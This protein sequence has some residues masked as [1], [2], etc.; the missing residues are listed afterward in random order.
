MKPVW[1]EHMVETLL[2]RGKEIL[3]GNLKKPAEI[4]YGR[5]TNILSAATVIM[6][7]IAASRLLGLA[8][9][10]VFVHYFPPAQLD[11]YLA[12]FQLPDLIFEVFIL[13]AMS[14]AFIPIFAKSLSEGKEKEAW[15]VAG[16]ILNVM[17]GLF[18]I[19]S[20]L[21]FVF[22]HPMYSLVAKGFTPDQISQTVLF[23][24]TL[25][26]AQMFFAASYV[27]TA[28]LESNQRF[29]APAVA[30]LF[31]NLGIILT[32]ILLVPSLG[33][34][35]PVWGAVIGSFLHLLVQVP[36]VIR[37]GFRPVW[38]FDFKDP[39]LRQIARLALPR[40]IDL[41]AFQL[42][43]LVDLFLASMVVGG[44]T[45]FKFGDSVAVLPTSLFGLSIA[46]A[47]LPT[48]AVETSKKGMNEF[49]AT[50]SSS[51]RQI[52]FFVIPASVFLSILR[53][54]IVR[55]AFGGAHF[56]WEDTLQTGY[57]LTAF[58]L[59]IFAYS[60][61]LLV[62]R[63]FYA[64]HDTMTPVTVTFYTIGINVLLELALIL[65]LKTPI[66]GLAL[67]Y[68]IAGIIQLA[69]LFYL[70]AKKVGGF[71]GFN[72]TQSF[73]K[74][75]AASSFSGALMFFLLRVLDRAAWDKQLSFL[76]KIGLA[77]P[78]FERVALDTHHTINLVILTIIVALIGAVAYL[79]TTW[80]LGVR[81]LALI[82]RAA[83]KVPF[84]APLK[85]KLPGT[86]KEDLIPPQTDG[87]N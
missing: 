22:A 42:K 9:N 61:A 67:A 15:R 37:L 32:T 78:I 40:V 35:A 30:P 62:S 47:S 29:L 11:T 8:R 13:G 60:L 68:S 27:F 71:K 77:L 87:T 5:Q 59:G 44:L 48:L 80:F 18:A 31:Y 53:V 65:G 73:I 55:I 50:F 86:P 45:Y 74:V 79:L 83:A 63:A 46:K 57:V 58:A 76:G 36:P 64:L 6:V 85:S 1:Q 72:I 75:L 56:T 23:T 3:S 24:R 81:E 43:R 12:A 54:P 52:L 28:V 4:L 2:K 10:R 70:L 21:I 25:L 69:I 39:K 7:T 49:R 38:S 16:L 51:F 41:G 34:Y 82:V 66:W 19:V 14:S 84:F 26:L 33:L 20:S 17:V